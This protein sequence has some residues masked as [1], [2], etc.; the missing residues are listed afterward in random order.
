VFQRARKQSHATVPLK[1]WQ[2]GSRSEINSFGSATL[3]HS[4]GVLT[5]E[6]WGVEAVGPR[7]GVRH[8]GQGREGGVVPTQ[9]AHGPSIHQFVERVRS[10]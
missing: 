6:V 3:D 8:V 7:A 4:V 9:H 5:V 10:K 2:V 1:T